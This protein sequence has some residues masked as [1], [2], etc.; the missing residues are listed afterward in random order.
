[1]K[2]LVTGAT[3]FVAHQLIPA[4]AATGR[5]VVALG[6]DKTRMLSVDGVENVVADLHEPV[7]RGTVGAVDAVVHLAQAN[8]PFP[9]GA[10][11]LFLVNAG[12][13]QDLLSLASEVGASRFVFFSSGSVYGL[14]SERVT[15]DSSRRAGDFYATTKRIGELLV[16]SY[17]S[18]MSTAVLRLFAPYGPGQQRRLVPAL[19]ARVRERRPVTLNDGGRPRMTPIFVGDVVRVVERALETD[20]NHVVNVAGDE[21]VGIGELARVIGDVLGVKPVFEEGAESVDGDLVAVNERMHALYG[22]D[23]LMPL[24]EAMARTVEAEVPA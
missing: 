9:A 3:G 10:R 16:E 18:A 14:G 20:G 11:S 22:I 6:H 23:E 4:L 13:T 1:M 7:P 15:E 2:V 19:I 5:E 24:R 8:V 12:S 17:G 21:I